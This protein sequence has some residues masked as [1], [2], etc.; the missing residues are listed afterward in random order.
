MSVPLGS[1]KTWSDAQLAEDMNDEDG[2]SA[3]KYNECWRWAKMHKEEVEWRA[4]E[5]AEQMA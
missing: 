1:I 4:W 5:E 3:V 2:V